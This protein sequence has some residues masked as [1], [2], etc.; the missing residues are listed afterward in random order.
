MLKIITSGILLQNNFEIVLTQVI[1]NDILH[2]AGQN[3]AAMNMR[4]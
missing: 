4:N 3:K 1:C 2:F